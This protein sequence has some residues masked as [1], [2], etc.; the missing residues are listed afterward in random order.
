LP[1]VREAVLI[2]EYNVRL[3]SLTYVSAGHT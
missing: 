2:D 1:M 3:L